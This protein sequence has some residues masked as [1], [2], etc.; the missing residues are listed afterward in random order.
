MPSENTSRP[1]TQ[2]DITVLA[3]DIRNLDQKFGQLDAKVSHID[4]KV[5]KL[6]R[7]NDRLTVELVK[8]QADILEMKTIMAT[9]DDISRILAAIDS[10]SGHMV[11]NRRTI[12][13]YDKILGEHGEKLESHEKRLAF[14]ESKS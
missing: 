14:I 3:Q 11:D 2:A 10:L 7:K 4:V 12:L 6:D 1:A 5:E 13:V 8:T 9:K